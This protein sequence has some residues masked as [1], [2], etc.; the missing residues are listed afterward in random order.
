MG[1]DERTYAKGFER[2]ANAIAAFVHGD[3]AGRDTGVQGSNGPAVD[4]DPE[5]GHPPS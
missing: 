2:K 3:A 1:Q 5:A 4:D